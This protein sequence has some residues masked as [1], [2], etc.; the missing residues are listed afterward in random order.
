MIVTNLLSAFADMIAQRLQQPQRAQC[1]DI[2]G[3][4]W[5][6]ERYLNVTLGSEVI[7]LIGSDLIQDMSERGS[8]GDISYSAA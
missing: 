1:I 4:F 8:V 7:H 5:D 6:V 3:V 2:G